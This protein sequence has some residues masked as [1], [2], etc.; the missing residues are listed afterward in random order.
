MNSSRPLKILLILAAKENDPIN[1]KIPFMPLSLPILASVAPENDY[2]FIDMLAGE[3]IDYTI[4]ADIV[5]ISYRQSSEKTTYSIADKFLKSGY[6]VVLGGAQASAVPHKAIQHA[7]SVF[8]GEGELLWPQFL[9][10]YRNNDQKSFYVC[11]P[12]QFDPKGKSL[13]QTTEFPSLENLPTPNRKLFSKKYHFELTYASKGCPIN[14]DFCAVSDMYGKKMRFRPTD[15]V[16]NEIRTFKRFYYLLDETVFGR[17]NCYNYYL[18]LY[19]KLSKFKKTIYWTGQ[20]NTDAASD[21][22]GRKVIQKASNAGL[23]YAAVGLESINKKTLIESGAFSKMGIKDPE[24]YLNQIK[25]NIRFIQSNGIFM[26]GWFAI[27]YEND[28]IQT[29]YDTLDFCLEMNIMPVFT[30]VR[31]I[32][33][34]RL[35]HKMKEQGRLQEMEGHISNIKHPVMNDLETARALTETIRRGYSG[36]ACRKRLFKY[37]KELKKAGFKR[38]DIIHRMIFAYIT[39][40]KLRKISLTENQYFIKQIGKEI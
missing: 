30:P 27:G 20:A 7:N 4:E 33:G 17:K 19:E 31:A 32:S 1:K 13:F 40:K 15:E 18:E 36:K 12:S 25:A 3:Q 16:V 10:D 14:C 29:Y 35:W 39:Q 24:D 38:S 11:S 26:S 6:Y 37:F 22:T 21:E 9:N 23:V 5:G 34:T 28:S 8:V 2:T